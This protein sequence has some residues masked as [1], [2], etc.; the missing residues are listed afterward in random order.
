MSLAL[1]FNS[2]VSLLSFISRLPAPQSMGSFTAHNGTIPT[3]HCRLGC[4]GNG[5]LSPSG[6]LSSPRRQ[7]EL[8]SEFLT[9]RLS[10]FSPEIKET[11][12][13]FHH[14]SVYFLSN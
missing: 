5:S 10:P 14:L 11:E 12:R 9:A 13:T 4:V 3:R 7:W 6:G 2:W 8:G 1:L